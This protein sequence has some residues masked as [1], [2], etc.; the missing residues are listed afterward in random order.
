M[1][2]LINVDDILKSDGMD[3]DIII[4]K[5]LEYKDVFQKLDKY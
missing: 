4:E 3:R 1:K 2:A 5:N